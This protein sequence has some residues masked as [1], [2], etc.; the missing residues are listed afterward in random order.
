MPQDPVRE[1]HQLAYERA[2]TLLDRQRARLMETRTNGSI[3]IAATALAASFLGRWSLDKGEGTFAELAIAAFA[4]G[5][6]F[7][8][9]PLWPV[10]ITPRSGQRGLIARLLPHIEAWSMTE[11]RA[12][13]RGPTGKEILAIDDQKAATAQATLALLL[14][15]CLEANSRI[16][17]RRSTWV[18]GCAI[19]LA[20]QTL[21]WIANAAAKGS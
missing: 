12:W 4:L 10:M 11:E 6:L 5:I 7:G 1:L 20:A 9:A 15:E 3:L 19:C 2:A 14:T 16:V 18:V 13:R 21:F 8:V 17:R